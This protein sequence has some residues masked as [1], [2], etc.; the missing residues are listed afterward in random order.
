VGLAIGLAVGVGIGFFG[1]L[2]QFGCAATAPPNEDPATS[3]AITV[4][5]GR[6]SRSGAA[7]TAAGENTLTGAAAE[8]DPDC[9]YLRVDVL[10][11]GQGGDADERRASYEIQKPY[12]DKFSAE[13]ERVGFKA[14]EPFWVLLE[15]EGFGELAAFIERN[16]EVRGRGEEMSSARGEVELEEIM[17]KLTT[18]EA[19][20][21]QQILKKL[22][23][24][25]WI[26]YSSVLDIPK[27][28]L[29][30][31]PKG[32]GIIVWNWSM[33]K[34][35]TVLD[36][37]L[38]IDLFIDPTVDNPHR[39]FGSIAGHQ[40]LLKSSFEIAAAGAAD[41]A[42]A[43]FFSHAKQLCADMNA[44][45][46]DEEAELERIRE[47]LTDEIIRVRERRAEQEKQLKLEVEQ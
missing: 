19:E 37:A 14:S 27:S 4:S 7:T 9:P 35:P 30:A 22:Q 42:S 8:I 3:R 5:Q 13:L 21:A 43:V 24:N 46:V 18:H 16:F 10:T 23:L 2:S 38:R 45:L 29:K 25:S 17:E 36:G 32:G 41:R 31:L 1:V 20:R 28:L 15:R 34:R 40:L 33:E 12:M 6:T 44:T 11:P 47:Q 39:R 26:A